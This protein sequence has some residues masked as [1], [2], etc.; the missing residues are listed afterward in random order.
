MSFTIEPL[1]LQ[2]IFIN[3]FSGSMLIFFFVALLGLGY[4]AGKLRMNNMIFLTMIGLFV[5][6]LNGF[7]FSMF[8]GIVILI[9]ALFFGLAIAKFMK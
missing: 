8:Y 6:M 3:Y 2:E 7:G 5:I 4:L 1:N 9:A